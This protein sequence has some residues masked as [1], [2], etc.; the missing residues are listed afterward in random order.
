MQK[1]EIHEKRT[2]ITRTQKGSNISFTEL[3][4]QLH[5]SD[6]PTTHAHWEHATCAAYLS[7]QASD[8]HGWT[9]WVVRRSVSF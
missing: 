5:V 9:R 2:E 4:P 1:G 3:N 8:H 7:S 6:H